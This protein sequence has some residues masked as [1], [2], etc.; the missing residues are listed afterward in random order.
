MPDEDIM[1]ENPDYD[2]EEWER[3]RREE[4][5]AKLTPYRAIAQAMRDRDELIAELLFEI[6]MLE[7]EE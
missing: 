5:E 6:T 1:M 7:L 2:P 3:K 4:E